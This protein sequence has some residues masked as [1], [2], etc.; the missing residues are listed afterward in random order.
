M[1]GRERRPGG[2]GQ[3][4]TNLPRLSGN[5]SNN[6]AY[7]APPTLPAN[8]HVFQVAMDL[9]LFVYSRRP[10]ETFRDQLVAK[11]PILKSHS[12]YSSTILFHNFELYTGNTA[13]PLQSPG[14]NHTVL[15][16]A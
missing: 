12:Y 14:L 6:C 11:K 7:T 15:I 3:E 5:V 9:E 13:A 8:N 4:C 10:P 16:A 2:G 1:E